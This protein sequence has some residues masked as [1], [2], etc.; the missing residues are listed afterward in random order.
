MISIILAAITNVIVNYL[1]IPIFGAK[2][3]I[4]ATIISEFVCCIAMVF[5]AGK[6]LHIKKVVLSILPLFIFGILS[7]QSIKNIFVCFKINNNILL[8]CIEIVGGGLVYIILTGIY[9][10]LVLRKFRRMKK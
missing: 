2:G 8:M 3:A 5:V 7:Y 1:L 4:F 6:L 9:Y 10:I